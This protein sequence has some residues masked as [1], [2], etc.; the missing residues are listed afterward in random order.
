MVHVNL[1]KQATTLKDLEHVVNT[2]R[3]DYESS[4]NHRLRRWLERFSSRLMHY[5][6][7]FDVL[8]QHHPEYV[9][10][11][12]G[13]MKVLFIVSYSPKGWTG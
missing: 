6:K 10:L 1:V 8:A 13:A 4:R 12:W 2:V 7:V 5:A 3:S 11:A 9:S